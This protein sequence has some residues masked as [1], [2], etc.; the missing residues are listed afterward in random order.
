[1]ILLQ[2]QMKYQSQVSI[3]ES[4][5]F[6]TVD[7]IQIINDGDNYQVGNSA[8][9]DNTGTNGGFECFS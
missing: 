4:T 5:T 2:N 1:M 6:G 9:F 3:V 7:S 8:T